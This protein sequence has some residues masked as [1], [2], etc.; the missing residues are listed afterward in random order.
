MVL[1]TTRSLP[2]LKRPP[3]PP[4]PP[5]RAAAPAPTTKA[6]PPADPLG[7]T[8]KPNA[9]GVS[10]TLGW[11]PAAGNV[12]SY[13]MYDAS[14]NVQKAGMARIATG[15][16][17]G[18][19]LSGLLP[20][21][22]YYIAITAVGPG[23]ESPGTHRLVLP[24]PSA[25]VTQAVA[26]APAAPTAAPQSTQSVPED[27]SIDGGAPSEDAS[28][29]GAPAVA[30]YDAN[31]NPVDS[32]GNPVPGA[33]TLAQVMSAVASYDSSGDPLDEN[34][35]VI[36]GAPTMAMLTAS[37]ATNLAAGIPGSG[38][39]ATGAPT[40]SIAQPV[41][42]VAPPSGPNLWLWGSVAAALGLALYLGSD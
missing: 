8:A 17:T 26:A 20:G 10:A 36:S 38:V 6:M 37:G 29:T 39:P 34:G 15:V 2:T 18:Y 28:E 7:L 40:T 23:G 5:G 22:T 3:P 41:S 32:G 12:S 31:G 1:S 42:M 4:P 33:P 25:A 27:T 24:M 9:D 13:N 21:E 35:N 30:G 14:T 16:Q 11:S 19:Q